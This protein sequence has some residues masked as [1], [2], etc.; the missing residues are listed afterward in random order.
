MG[1]WTSYIVY[2]AL[3]CIYKWHKHEYENGMHNPI[4]LLAAAFTVVQK[5]TLLQSDDA[6]YIYAY[7]MQECRE[8]DL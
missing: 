2:I 1:Q 8:A 4:A 5:E 3:I 7:R 6:N